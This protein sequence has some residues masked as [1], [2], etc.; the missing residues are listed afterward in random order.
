M[1]RH[2]LI[3][4]RYIF[5]ALDDIFLAC[6]YIFRQSDDITRRDISPRG[7]AVLVGFY[8][9]KVKRTAIIFI[10]MKIGIDVDITLINMG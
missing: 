8:S 1:H 6:R 7:R 3:P 4:Q 10:L 5:R 2:N 9:F